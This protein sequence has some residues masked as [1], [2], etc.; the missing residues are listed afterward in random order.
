[1]I[2]EVL[3]NQFEIIRNRARRTKV[4]WRNSTFR[5]TSI[6]PLWHKYKCLSPEALW[7]NTNASQD[8]AKGLIWRSHG[9]IWKFCGISLSLYGTEQ[10]DQALMGQFQPGGLMTRIQIPLRIRLEV[11]FDK[12]WDCAR[13]SIRSVSKLCGTISGDNL[14]KSYVQGTYP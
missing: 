3:Y 10:K 11:Q 6:H 2:C 7:H 14:K 4:I 9:T 12:L 1:M 5:G 13:G 8:H